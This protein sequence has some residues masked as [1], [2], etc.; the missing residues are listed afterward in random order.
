[1]SG[2]IA[3]SA[4]EVFWVDRGLDI[5][6]S[7][8]ALPVADGTA[9]TL[10]EARPGSA[11][12]EDLVVD[13]TNV[14]WVEVNTTSSGIQSDLKA[15]PQQGGTPTVLVSNSD[16]KPQIMVIAAVGG[17][18]V[19]FGDDVAWLSRVP[20]TGGKPTKVASWNNP[21]TETTSVVAD[22]QG[23][24]W[25]EVDGSS[26]S[27]VCEPAGASTQTVIDSHQ[28]A[29]TALAM[30]GSIVAWATGNEDPP[31]RTTLKAAPIGGGSPTVLTTAATY[32]IALAADESGLYY[33]DSNGGCGL[34]REAA[35][36]WR[37]ARD[38]RDRAGA[39]RPGAHLHRGAR[40]RRHVGLLHRR[41]ARIDSP[42]AE[43][44]CRTFASSGDTFV[45][46]P[47]DGRPNL[48]EDSGR[49]DA[50]S[51]RNALRTNEHPRPRPRPRTRPRPLQPKPPELLVQPLARDPR[52][53]SPP[54]SC[55]S[56]ARAA[57]R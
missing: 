31:T 36:R 33:V 52:G 11:A 48:S 3:A 55:C 28:P 37:G 54:P 47:T 40:A 50:R 15:M 27:V 12:I 4:S 16:V 51:R 30:T 10:Y 5:V 43:V 22:A 13:D 44:R 26:M 18:F 20:T 39:C 17:G 49:I 38:D 9:K 34:G 25:T 23:A 6:D 19:Y 7:I 57:P 21:G 46:A 53:P 41:A 56:R 42:G 45:T 35:P 24:C 14:Y 32:V 8:R 29:V 1:M 2:E